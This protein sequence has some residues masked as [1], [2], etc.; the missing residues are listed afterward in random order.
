MVTSIPPNRRGGGGHESHISAG[1][2]LSRLLS[3]E[4]VNIL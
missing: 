3:S 1:Q 2:V 4:F